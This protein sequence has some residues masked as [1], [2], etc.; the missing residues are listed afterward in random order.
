MGAA[1]PALQ[2]VEIANASP[3]RLTLV[4]DQ[5]LARGQECEQLEGKL[6]FLAAQGLSAVAYVSHVCFVL[7]GK[8]AAQVKRAFRVMKRKS[9]LPTARFIEGK[10]E[11]NLLQLESQGQAMEAR[12]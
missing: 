6:S 4:F 11:N 7:V 3:T 12:R 8:D 9:R 5:S 10:P 1:P 2:L